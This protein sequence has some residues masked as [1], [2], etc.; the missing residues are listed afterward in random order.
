MYLFIFAIKSHWCAVERCKFV[1]KINGFFFSEHY[2]QFVKNKKY[3]GDRQFSLV[4]KTV[5]SIGFR[6]KPTTTGEKS[7]NRRGSDVV[8]SATRARTAGEPR[9][10]GRLRGWRRRGACA[11]SR[12]TAVTQEPVSRR[13]AAVA[14]VVVQTSPSSFA[15]TLLSRVHTVPAVQSPQAHVPA[16][17]F[18]HLK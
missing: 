1:K 2:V 9:G 10:R 15:R 13:I 3:L 18:R 16:A 11:P 12:D 8:S 5:L 4:G 7:R 14:V 6:H 17:E